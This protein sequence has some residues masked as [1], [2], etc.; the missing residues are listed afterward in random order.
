M[1]ARSIKS[2]ILCIVVLSLAACASKSKP[3]NIKKIY[4][5]TAQYHLPDRNPIIVIP[6]ILGSSLIDED[7]G[8]SVW[9]AFR[10]NYA[11]P[12][13]AEGARLI[14]LSLDPDNPT[15]IDHVRPNGVL[16]DLELSLAGFPITIQA[17][18]GILT[19]LG[20]GGYRDESLGLTSI[21]YGTDHFTCFQFDYDWRRDITYNAKVL[22]DFIEERRAFVQKKYK[23]DYGIEKT[24]IKFD[25]VAHSMGSLLT[26]YY[27]RYGDA[28][29]PKDGSMPELTWAG[30]Q[31]VERTVLVAPPNAGSLEAFEQ[32]IEGFNTGR[33]I[34]PHYSPAILGTFPSV[35]QLLPRSRHNAIVW[36]GDENKPIKDIYDPELWQKHGWGL[37]S[38]DKE[39]DRVIAQILPHISDKNERF[40]IASNF[41][42][43]ALAR[44]QQ[45]QAALD[46]PAKRPDGLD[47]FLVAGDTADTP[48]IMS[49]D[50]QS[51]D[52]DILQNGIGDKTV[53]RSSA[54]L[55]ERVGGTWTPNVQTPIDW[56][57]VLF[58][59]SQHRKITSHPVFEDN[60]LYWLLEDPRIS[61]FP[62]SALTTPAYNAVQANP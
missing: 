31:D 59:P 26:R 15:D 33:P 16:E 37:S 4:D 32:L 54:L 21:D 1:L 2:I 13:T 29:L 52:V 10:A 47:L 14:S 36:D 61:T 23:E 48:A 57:S 7:T 34:L 58:V 56:T 49:V 35:Y 44:A 30:A 62:S 25:I 53:L 60:I 3:A 42:A 17:Y 40:K 51:G 38:Q 11:D 43:K 9:G 20:A 12:N 6:G 22:K 5:K 41:Q 39:A 46:S 55:D 24:D 50:S 19:T 18:A 27:L 8:Q 28:P 45:F